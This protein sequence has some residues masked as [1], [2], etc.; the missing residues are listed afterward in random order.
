M[1][2]ARAGEG[3]VGQNCRGCPGAVYFP[4]PAL[5]GQAPTLTSR[6]GQASALPSAL[7]N[8]CFSSLG[9]EAKSQERGAEGA[10]RLHLSPQSLGPG[11]VCPSRLFPVS[12]PCLP[13]HVLRPDEAPH[14]RL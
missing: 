8:H 2:L 5:A 7:D 13:T 11:R 9:T 10:S 14:P 3:P 4:L 12:C 6:E 1:L